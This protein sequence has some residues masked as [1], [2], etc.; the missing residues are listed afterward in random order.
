[1]NYSAAEN[2]I[3]FRNF[4]EQNISG[5]KYEYTF[6]TNQIESALAGFDQ[7]YSDSFVNICDNN[8]KSWILV[9][10]TDKF[11]S[12]YG[13]NYTEEQITESLKVFDFADE[14]HTFLSGSKDLLLRIVD[15]AAKGKYRVEKSR[16]FYRLKQTKILDYSSYQIL[17]PDF[18]N[19]LELAEMLQAYY[20]EEYN[21]DNDKTI[22]QMYNKIID[23][24]LT[25]SIVIVTDPNTEQIISL[26]TIKDS[27]PGI[28]FTK[29]S[30]RN[31]GFGKVL[32]NFCSEQLLK[33]NE[34]IYVMT[35]ANVL[36]SN[37]IMENLGFEKFYE[38][39][40]VTIN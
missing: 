31:K 4:L 27:S 17:I 37:R 8:P 12:V 16:Y 26:C 15:I 19:A 38:Y 5:D 3:L 18:E 39:I 14:N 21:G 11:V 9:V 20:H 28:L 10:N 7:V 25:N 23:L 13:E 35:D 34:I 30:F 6:V 33:E 36:S 24:L 1:M 32:L 22:R 40:N 2:P 29:P